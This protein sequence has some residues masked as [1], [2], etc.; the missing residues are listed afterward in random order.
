MDDAVGALLNALEASV[1]A[2]TDRLEGEP[3][4]SAS[5]SHD[6][7]AARYAAERRRLPRS[8]RVHARIAPGARLPAIQQRYM[9]GVY[10]I[11]HRRILAALEK[12]SRLSSHLPWPP[13]RQDVFV[14]DGR[15]GAQCGHTHGGLCARGLSL[16]GGV[17]DRRAIVRKA[18]SRL[19][20]PRWTTRRSSPSR[21]PHIPILDP[22]RRC[23]EARCFSP[24]ASPPYRL[25]GGDVDGERKPHG[26]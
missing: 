9:P 8:S 24:S 26:H 18:R 17:H 14:S 2:I 20:R 13:H 5:S 4:T 11:V 23:L 22:V 3:P 25:G 7:T 10:R 16:V 1:N 15:Y 12:Y 6:R 21:E 19:L